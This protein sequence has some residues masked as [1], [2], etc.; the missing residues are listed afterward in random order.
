MITFFV[1]WV[2]G[3]MIALVVNYAIHA[4]NSKWEEIETYKDSGHLGDNDV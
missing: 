3:A 2:V 4:P 1:V